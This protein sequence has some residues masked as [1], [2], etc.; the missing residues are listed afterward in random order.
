MTKAINQTP[1]EN[2]RKLLEVVRTAIETVCN[3]GEKLVHLIGQAAFD[4]IAEAAKKAGVDLSELVAR[5]REVIDEAKAHHVRVEFESLLAISQNGK[6]VN[7]LFDY[8]EIWLPASELEIEEAVKVVIMPQ[9]LAEKHNLSGIAVT[10]EVEAEVNKSELLLNFIEDLVGCF[11]ADLGKSKPFNSPMVIAKIAQC[12]TLRLNL[13]RNLDHLSGPVVM[14]DAC[15][16][17]ELLSALSGREVNTWTAPLKLEQTEIIQITDGYYGITTLCNEQKSQNKKKAQPKR[18]FQRMMEVVN[19][20]IAGKE[21]ETLLVTWKVLAEDLIDWQAQGK[22]D[23]RVAVAWYGGIEGLN[24]FEDRKQVIL[25]GTPTAPVEDIVEMGQAIWANDPTPLNPE[26]RYVW[27]RYAYKDSEG[28][29]MEAQVWEFCADRLNLIL[30]TYREHEMIQAAHRIR[31]LLTAGKT[32]YLLSNLPIEELPP[33]RL[34]TLDKLAGSV[35][36]EGFEAFVGLVEAI[37]SQVRLNSK[38]GQ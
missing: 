37:L 20:I 18:A 15:A 7:L 16:Q 28:N 12:P 34:T 3:S 29:G 21:A 4:A 17:P 19:R 26:I 36:P 30:R 11:E 25:L 2:V 38:A 5:A 9:W 14:L 24:A 13:K 22:L 6:S 23:A 10:D 32:I 33:T 31:P 35:E 1:H 8:E 27:H